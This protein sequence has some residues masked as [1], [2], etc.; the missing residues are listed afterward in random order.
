MAAEPSRG[1]QQQP[2]EEQAAGAQE[3]AAE[4]RA[5]AAALQAS[6]LGRV[7]FLY[8]LVEGVAP[9]SYGLNVARMAQVRQG[10]ER[11]TLQ[12]A[13]VAAR[14]SGCTCSPLL[15]PPL[16][17]MHSLP[18]QLSPSIQLPESVITAA[19]TIAQAQAQAGGERR[20][21]AASGG[22]AATVEQLAEECRRF[23][24]LS[25]QPGGQVDG[26]AA[27]E[28]QRRVRQALAA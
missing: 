24:R 16:P 3:Q 18:S 23:L 20:R 7:V 11:A 15:A 9:A 28:L 10:L 4:A 13:C 21:T 1:E 26:E 17:L 12:A 19:A 8:R 27:L 25:L 22:S 6:A 14:E 2:G 5:R